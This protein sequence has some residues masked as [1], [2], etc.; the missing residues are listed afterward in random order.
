MTSHTLNR[1]TAVWWA[2]LL[3]SVVVLFIFAL[4]TPE[5]ALV[6][7]S[8]ARDAAI[9]SIKSEADVGRL[10][11]TATMYVSVGYGIGATATV[12]CRTAV[13]AFLLVIVGSI[14]G[15]VQIHRIKKQLKNAKD[16]G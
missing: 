11:Q 15:L 3:V 6:G 9:Q 14:A 5:V 16:V 8:T 7:S 1:L 10:Q 13:G 12:L 2:I 4:F